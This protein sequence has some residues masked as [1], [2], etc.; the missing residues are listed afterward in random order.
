MRKIPIAEATSEQIRDFGNAFLGLDIHA[1][2]G[3]EKTRARVLEAW[4]KDYIIVESVVHNVRE[5]A[6]SPL[7]ALMDER[8]IIEAAGGL[9]NGKVTVLIAAT[10]EKGGN[11]PVPVGVNGR[12]MLIPRSEPQEIPVAYYLVLRNAIRLK[13]EMNDDGKSMNPVPRKV[14]QYPH[15]LIMDARARPVSAVAA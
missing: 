1:N 6:H 12:V 8:E 15:Q 2:T 13:Y 3:A 11:E 5:S 4:D 7:S 14:Q 10:E 9:E